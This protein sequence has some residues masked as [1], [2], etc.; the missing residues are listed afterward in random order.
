MYSCRFDSHVAG[1]NITLV[2]KHAQSTVSIGPR[3]CDIYGTQK[4]YGHIVKC[5]PSDEIAN[6]LPT[7]ALVNGSRISDGVPVS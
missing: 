6:Y 4:K 2:A 5:M 3:F 1:I 7:F